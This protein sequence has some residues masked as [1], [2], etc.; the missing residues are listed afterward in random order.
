MRER[1]IWENEN[2]HAPVIVKP[3]LFIVLRQEAQTHVSGYVA[4]QCHE[5]TKET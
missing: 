4:L 5:G 2:H 1:G 3:F